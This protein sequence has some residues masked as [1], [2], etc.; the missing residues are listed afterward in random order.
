MYSKTLN[1]NHPTISIWLLLALNV[2]ICFSKQYPMQLYEI[3]NSDSLLILSDEI[4]I[5]KTTKSFGNGKHFRV[6]GQIKAPINEVFNVINKE[7]EYPKF[8]PR[9]NDVKYLY[10]ENNF[11]Y[12]TFHISLPLNI[13]YQYKIKI[14]E[15]QNKDVAWITWELV[16]WEHNSIADTWGQWYFTSLNN[17][18]YTLIQYQTYIDPGY[19]PFGAGWIIDLLT[20]TSLPQIVKNSKEYIESK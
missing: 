5:N 14:N 18:E 3:N 20:H 15:Y 7:E 19:V 17:S 16:D 12:Y 1:Y 10:T 8:M 2:G 6:Y 11:S 13:K 4:V 9:F